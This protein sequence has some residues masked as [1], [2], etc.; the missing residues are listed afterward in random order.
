MSQSVKFF[1]GRK[2]CWLEISKL[3]WY[4]RNCNFFILPAYASQVSMTS[5]GVYSCIKWRLEESFTLDKH[6][7]VFCSLLMPLNVYSL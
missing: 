7:F 4:V 5:L 1:L 2:G 3:F 6:Y